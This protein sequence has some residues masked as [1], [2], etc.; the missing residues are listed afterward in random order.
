MLGFDF[1]KIAMY[2]VLIF[3]YSVSKAS[4]RIWGWLVMEVLLM[5]IGFAT[6]PMLDSMHARLSKSNL[7]I[8]NKTLRTI[9]IK[10]WEKSRR[11]PLSVTR[12]F[13]NIMDVGS[14]SHL[15]RIN[16]SL[17]SSRK[18][19]KLKTTSKWS[20]MI[21]LLLISSFLGKSA[22]EITVENR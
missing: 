17:H 12:M 8:T 21:L 18:S 22:K 15:I 11:T 16:R 19:K 1:Q 2:S 20:L 13:W 4:S 5:S 6:K 10:C 3:L 14:N 7:A 9:S